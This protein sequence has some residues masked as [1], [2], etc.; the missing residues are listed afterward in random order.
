M[1]QWIYAEIL[2]QRSED[3]PKSIVG[4]NIAVWRLPGPANSGGQN[5]VNSRNRQDAQAPSG[6]D[7]ASSTADH[8]KR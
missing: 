3:L 5:S 7:P 8:A 6:Q 1:G 2:Q 4:G